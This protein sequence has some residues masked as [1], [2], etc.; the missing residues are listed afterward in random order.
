MTPR[1]SS[2]CRAGRCGRAYAKT[3]SADHCMLIGAIEYCGRRRSGQSLTP[4]QRTASLSASYLSVQRWAR[5]SMLSAHR[6]F[7]PAGIRRGRC[8]TPRLR[9]ILLVRATKS[10]TIFRH[11][12]Y[13]SRA[14][15]ALTPGNRPWPPF[16]RPLVRKASRSEGYPKSGRLTLSRR[17]LGTTLWLARS[18]GIAVPSSDHHRNLLVVAY[19]MTSCCP[20]SQ[21]KSMKA[22]LYLTITRPST[23][24]R[25]TMRGSMMARLPR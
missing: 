12:P 10:H 20:K 7:E 11:L 3:K 21:S 19:G 1:T 17:L 25:S 18:S 22:R 2:G 23:E 15:Q 9:S 5:Y 6:R 16:R 8:I 4:T 24:W 13:S 14:V